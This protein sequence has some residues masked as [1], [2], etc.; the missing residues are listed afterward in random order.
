MVSALEHGRRRIMAA[1]VI[2]MVLGAVAI[3]VP[4]VASVTIA[5]L[6]GWILLAASIFMGADALAIP[7]RR[8][9]VLRM[10]LAVLTFGAGLYLLVAPLDGVFTLTVMLVI[11]FVATGILRI[12]FGVAEWGVPGAWMT[13]LSGVLSLVL[14][15]LIAESLPSSADWAVGL[16]VG[17]DLLFAGA[18][19]V[20]L[21]RALPKART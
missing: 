14:G 19:L 7:D 4:A 11:W 1:G 9:Q 18:T 2:A 12:A 17:I 15:V 21:A 10:L 5:I 13:V 8:R 20:A 6:L 3:I 16:V